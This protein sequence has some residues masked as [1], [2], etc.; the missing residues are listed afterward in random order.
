[1]TRPPQARPLRGL[2][3]GAILAALTFVVATVGLYAPFVGI[4]LAPLPIMLLVIRWGIRTAV[5]ATVVAASLLL[6]V[7]GPLNAI[8][9][10]ALFAPLGLALGWGVWRHLRAQWTILIGAAA[11][12]GS[13]LAAMALAMTILHQDLVDEFIRV[14]VQAMQMALSVQKRL[15]ASA[16]QLDDLQKTITI[17]PQFLHTALPVLLALGALVWAYLSYIVARAVFRRIGHELPA[18]PAL[19]TWRLNPLL[20]PGLLWSAALV[21]L[22]GV[23]NPRTAGLALDAMIVVVFVFG[24]QGALVGLAWM[25]QRQI[26]RFG[27]VMAGV[28]VL[29]VGFYAILALAILGIMDTW[30]DYRRL[31]R[32]STSS[33]PGP[34]PQLA[35]AEDPG[36]AAGPEREL[37]EPGIEAEPAAKAGHP[38]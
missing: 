17:L 16:P 35:T 3:E 9:A 23:R 2:T 29:S 4:L 5:L 38:R 18:V 13:T 12:L 21:S 31:G 37:E 32:S 28:L 24:F 27:Q 8:S 25:K 11:F 22:V 6:Q 7:F 36:G 15:G 34:A 10:V 20:S 26:P 14:Q 33:T 30:F 1:M 19:L